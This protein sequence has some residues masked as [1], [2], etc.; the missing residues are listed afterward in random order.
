[1]WLDLLHSTPYGSLI[2]LQPPGLPDPWLGTR[3]NRTISIIFAPED[4]SSP[5]RGPDV[6]ELFG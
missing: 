1:M 6:E 4:P 5:L 3:G 2:S